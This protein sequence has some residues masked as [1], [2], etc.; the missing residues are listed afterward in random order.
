[1][2]NKPLPAWTVHGLAFMADGAFGDLPPAAGSDQAARAIS[3]LLPA[4]DAGTKENGP[5]ARAGAEG[6]GSAARRTHEEVA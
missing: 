6:N 4:S 1:V 5:A 3:V 2:T